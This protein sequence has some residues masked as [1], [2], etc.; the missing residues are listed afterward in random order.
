MYCRLSDDP[1]PRG[2]GA[3]YVEKGTAGFS[4]GSS[5]YT[6]P[7]SYDFM[8]RA[9]V[10]LPGF[11]GALDA[12]GEATADLPIPNLVQAIGV[13]LH[14]G[15]VV[16]GGP[17]SFGAGGWTNTEL[18]KALPVDFQIDNANQAVVFVD[19]RHHGVGGLIEGVEHLFQRIASAQ[20]AL[21]TV[22]TDDPRYAGIGFSRAAC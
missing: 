11:T 2:I 15:L 10:M 3:V 12:A 18:E 9:T 17:N 1:G 22:A 6:L 19:H 4:F 16:L 21:F 8:A 14:F 20:H 13:P 5:G 7:T